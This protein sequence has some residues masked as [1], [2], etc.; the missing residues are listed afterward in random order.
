M[1]PFVPAVVPEELNLIV[2]LVIGVAFG[3]VLEQAGFSSAKRLVGLFYGYDFTVLRVFFT[4]AITAC[5]GTLLLGYFGFLDLRVIF[6]NPLFLWP[7]IV[8]GAIMGVGF[9]LGGYCPGTSIAA[10]AIGKVDAWFFV[11]GG[12][13]GVLL[14]GVVY[15]AFKGFV[16]F[17]SFGDMKVF[18]PLHMSQG[19]FVFVLVAFAVLA[20]VITGMI[21]RKVSPE[22]APSKEFNKNLHMAAAGVLIVLAGIV[23][24]LPDRQAAL[25]NKVSNPAYVQAHP[26]YVMEPDELAIHLVQHNPRFKVYDLRDEKA[27]AKSSL[28]GAMNL[29]LEDLF[30]SVYA[31]EFAHSH[32]RKIIVADDQ[33]LAET[34]VRLLEA[35][36]FENLAALEGGFANIQTQILDASP[37][38]LLA[39]NDPVVR[40]FRSEAQIEL[41]RLVKEQKA[42]GAPSTKKVVAVKGGC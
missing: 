7:A 39:I 31:E 29:K 30:T 32:I 34:A 20:F 3:Y 27:F 42:K 11:G 2:A 28:P 23:A 25:T 15:P 16:D 35:M 37:E 13:L 22:K 18:D 38:T 33:K 10:A 21:E 6:I 14:Y 26:I 17:T 41:R 24:L 36:G 9:I 12:I 1:G 40:E 4:A 5:L 8:G 19:A